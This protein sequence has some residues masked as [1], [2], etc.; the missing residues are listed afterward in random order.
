MGG[1]GVLYAFRML[2]RDS[3]FKLEL[4]P[5]SELSDGGPGGGPWDLHQPDQQGPGWAGGA[6]GAEAGLWGGWGASVE[7]AWTTEG[8]RRRG[9]GGAATGIAGGAGRQSARCR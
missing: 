9:K 8:G 3:T 6:G 5:L 4:E 7:E 1:R 2:S